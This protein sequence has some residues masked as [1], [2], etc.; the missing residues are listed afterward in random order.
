MNASY[1]PKPIPDQV[2]RMTLEDWDLLFQ[3]V[4]IRLRDTMERDTAGH[5]MSPMVLECLETLEQLLR[6]HPCAMSYVR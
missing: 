3:A 1:L 6:S 2:Y 4:L 5:T